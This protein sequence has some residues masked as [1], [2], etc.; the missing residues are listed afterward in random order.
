M[1]APTVPSV[2]ILRLITRVHIAL[3]RLTG[4]IIGGFLGNAPNLLLT[5]TGRRSGKQF[6]TPLLFLPDSKNLVIVASYG[7]Q[8]KD[9]QWWQNLQIDP[10]ATVE[11]GTQRWTVLAEQADA[12]TKARL[13]PVFC[14]YY[15][16]YIE[17]Q[18]RTERVIPLVVLIP[19]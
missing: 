9:P 11:V 17:Y 5:T 8:P 16:G 19:Q 6:T 15:P 4:G 3:Y 2:R 1:T 18:Q 10:R 14:R 7:G 12:E 13:W